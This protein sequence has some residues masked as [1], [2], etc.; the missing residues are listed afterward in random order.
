MSGWKKI[1]VVFDCWNCFPSFN[2]KWSK[3]TVWIKKKLHQDLEEVCIVVFRELVLAH[4]R[5]PMFPVGARNRS[6]SPAQIWSA[7]LCCSRRNVP[8]DVYQWKD[9]GPPQPMVNQMDLQANVTHV[10]AAK[11]HWLLP[12]HWKDKVRSGNVCFCV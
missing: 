8:I 11:W 9:S 6:L 10:S 3:Y 5:N 1:H 12:L 7:A 4:K 2:P